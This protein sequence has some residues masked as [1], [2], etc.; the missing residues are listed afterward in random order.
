M[1]YEYEYKQL[2][3]ISKAE[4]SNADNLTFQI[5]DNLIEIFSKDLT[6]IKFQE[7]ELVKRTEDEFIICEKI[8]GGNTIH[9]A[10][11]SK[12]QDLKLLP[13]GSIALHIASSDGLQFDALRGRAFTFLPLPIYTGLPIHINAYFE[14]S[15]NRR[16]LWLDMHGVG[17]ERHQWNESILQDVLAP[18]YAYLIEYLASEY[19]TTLNHMLKN[20]YQLF[21]NKITNELFRGFMQ[22]FYSNVSHSNILYSELNDETWVSPSSTVAF[23]GDNDEKI[24]NIRIQQILSTCD[25]NVV[26]LNK[27]IINNMIQYKSGLK[28]FTSSWL[29]RAFISISGNLSKLSSNDC[30]FLLEQC[31]KDINASNIDEL[32]NIPIIPLANG[33]FASI[34]PN[35]EKSDRQH[36]FFTNNKTFIS[37]LENAPDIEYDISSRIISDNLSQE[38][39]LKLS[40]QNIV[41]NTNISLETHETLIELLP[42]LLPKRHS[43]EA[44]VLWNINDSDSEHPSN[45][46]VENI[47]IYLE[48]VEGIMILLSHL[49]I[50]PAL[51]YTKFYNSYKCQKQLIKPDVKNHVFIDVRQFN[52]PLRQLLYQIGF[53]CIEDD[54]IFRSNSAHKHILQ[55]N[56]IGILKGIRRLINNSFD[57]T[58]TTYCNE[59]IDKHCNINQRI[60][61]RD[62]MVRCLQNLAYK[63]NTKERELI[64]DFILIIKSIPIY[65]LYTT[66][67][68]SNIF[69]SLNNKD[70]IDIIWP[71]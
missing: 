13:F 2:P 46:W 52:E 26:T 1:S 6:E 42:I 50:V 57:G 59:M 69:V 37:I 7:Q 36:L 18:S 14:L 24:N 53:C 8:G 48:G 45:E 60:A 21:P 22:S 49:C 41:S 61:L 31:L 63:N 56:L 20:Y 3:V 70:N 67:D 38:I 43:T 9:I 40:N 10:C 58:I 34:L 55:S 39:Q 23:A 17:A 35:T 54:Y 30:E 66:K 12:K 71:P 11:N 68:E 32:Y 28:L 25:V 29:R 44:G 16:D 15:A 65:Q 5:I 27:N 19:G 62:Y 64:L 33:D 4:A 47:W 51:R